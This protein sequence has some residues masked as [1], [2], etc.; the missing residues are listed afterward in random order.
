MFRKKALALGILLYTQET[1]LKYIGGLHLYLRHSFLMFNP[2]NSDEVCVQEIHIESG[3]RNIDFRSTREVPPT[4]SKIKGNE[5][6][7]TT[8]KK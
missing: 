4:E 6:K 7:T 8:V 3:G 1:L 5:K 2:S